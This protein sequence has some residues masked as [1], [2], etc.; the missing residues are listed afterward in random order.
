[1][2][3]QSLPQ[4]L[5]QE[6]NS[7]KSPERDQQTLNEK[8]LRRLGKYKRMSRRMTDEELG[9]GSSKNKKVKMS[10]D[11]SEEEQL[12]TAR[13]YEDLVKKLRDKVECPVCYVI[14]R[15]APVPVCPNGHIVCEN[16]VRE[17]CPTCRVRMERGTSTLA[18]TVIENIEHEC[19]NEGCDL[20]FSLADLP[21]HMS[22]C[23]HRK[24]KCPGQACTAWLPLSSFLDHVITCCVGRREGIRQ[25]TGMPVSIA[26]RLTK[27]IEDIAGENLTVN[28]KIQGMEFEGQVFFLRLV[29]KEE[30]RS[31]FFFVQ[32][33]GSS[34]DTEGFGV[35]ITVYREGDG[36]EG[37]YSRKYSGEVC[38]IDISTVEE[39][40]DKGLCLTLKDGGMAKFFVKN[41]I[42]GKNEISVL[43]NIFQV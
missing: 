23:G 8:G 14:P 39:A 18:V 30:A 25:C 3:G 40:A 12:A 16:C 37:R 7:N 9:L 35:T 10:V 13:K 21:S 1:V 31:W 22:R 2:S 5:K 15:K 28:R 11:S 41:T 36:P 29:R 32:M 6:F 38:P 20:T 26:Y 34:E 4:K 19:D 27:D 17:T 42:L 24:V 43:V 33:V